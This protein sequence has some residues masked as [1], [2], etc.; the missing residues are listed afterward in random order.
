MNFSLPLIPNDSQLHSPWFQLDYGCNA[1]LVKCVNGTSET[2]I[3]VVF[4]DDFIAGLRVDRRTWVLLP[5]SAVLSVTFSML[6]SRN[7]PPVRQVSQEG[8]TYLQSLGQVELKVWLVAVDEPLPA[9]TGSVQGR[10]LALSREEPGKTERLVPFEAI[11]TIEV[12]DVD[13]FAA[14]SADSGNLVV[15]QSRR[16]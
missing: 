10:W 12:T 11:R 3:Y 1:A 9:S 8:R 5:S 15:G 16:S 13:N 7:L 4:G 2:L 6:G 14:M